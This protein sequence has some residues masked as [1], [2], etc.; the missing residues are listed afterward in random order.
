LTVGDSDRDPIEVVILKGPR[1][2]RLFGSG[3]FFTYIPNSSFG[4][5]VFTYKPW[6]G[7]NFGAE[8]QVRIEQAVIPPTSPGFESVRLVESGL[9]QLSMTNQLGKAFRIEASADFNN[10]VTLTNV[11]SSSGRFFFNTPVTNSRIYYRAVQ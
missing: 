8:A 5:D 6:D 10:W 4:V 7:R 9:F 11:T 1:A 2:G 3:T